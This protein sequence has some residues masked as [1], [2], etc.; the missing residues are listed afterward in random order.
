M[1]NVFYRDAF[2]NSGEKNRR[3]SVD[4]D[5]FTVGVSTFFVQRQS[6]TLSRSRDYPNFR[7]VSAGDFASQITN[8]QYL[9]PAAT[10]KYY[11]KFFFS[12]NQA[13]FCLCIHQSIHISV[14]GPKVFGHWDTMESQS[15]TDEIKGLKVDLEEVKCER[16]KLK[17]TDP[18]YAQLTNEITETLRRLNLLTEQKGKFAS[19]IS[20]VLSHS[21]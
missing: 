9:L 11:L 18:L 4:L 16:R 7:N 6:T 8:N 3:G 13:R 12:R 20:V 14:D 19:H 15:Q 10:P 5:I 2:E 1:I 17:P 21:Y